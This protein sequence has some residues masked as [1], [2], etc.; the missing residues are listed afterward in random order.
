MQK[1]KTLT[2]ILAELDWRYILKNAIKL[3]QSSWSQ[4]PVIE[5]RNAGDT[6]YC[7]LINEL[8][9]RGYVK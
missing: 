5:W 9:T 4:N 8:R 3:R 1:G 2:E 7:A 6:I